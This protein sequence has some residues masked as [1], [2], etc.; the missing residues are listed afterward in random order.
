M[1][2]VMKEREQQ[3]AIKQTQLEQLQTVKKLRDGYIEAIKS[4]SIGAG[5]FNK[6]IISQEQNMGLAQRMGAVRK[7]LLLG[8]TQQPGAP[9]VSSYRYGAF[10][11]FEKTGGG[12][13]GRRELGARQ[14]VT[15][16]RTEGF[17]RALANYGNNLAQS[18]NS[19]TNSMSGL[20]KALINQTIA[21]QAAA[22]AGV[23]YGPQ[24]QVHAQSLGASEINRR[25]LKRLG[26]K[27]RSLRT[28]ASAPGGSNNTRTKTCS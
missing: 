4:M 11:G 25:N 7:N 27:N 3:T 26:T 6:L 24:G 21:T 10:G 20:E 12:V 23:T 2:I 17:Q 8:S 18:T 5:S 16:G 28:P 13:M 19:M 14:G 1:A 22:A 15:T 9:Q